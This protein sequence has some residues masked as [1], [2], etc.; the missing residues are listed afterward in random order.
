MTDLV[1]IDLNEVVAH[2][3]GS[4][5]AGTPATVMY[6]N[7]LA[8]GGA[9]AIVSPANSHGW[10]DGGIDLHYARRWPGLEQRTQEMIR[11]DWNGLLPV[12]EAALVP[13]EDADL[14][15]MICAPT[16]VTPGPV[17]GTQNAFLAMRAALRVAASNP[18]IRRILCPGLC[19][20][21][22]CM[23]P[24]IAAWQMRAAWEATR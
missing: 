11:R 15:F 5:F 13:T 7:I 4:A 23:P 1:F 14:P 6:G 22:G 9:D 20:L 8:V 2:A 17:P 19:T 21:S 16:M 18:G 24:F 10:M 12:G 3:L